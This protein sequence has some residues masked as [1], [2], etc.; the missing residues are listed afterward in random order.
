MIFKQKKTGRYNDKPF[1]G[2]SGTHKTPMAREM[3]T[4]TIVSEIA[5]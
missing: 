2:S 5:I 1:R 4:M 3:R